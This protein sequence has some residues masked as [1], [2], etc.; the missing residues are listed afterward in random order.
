MDIRSLCRRH[1]K[2]YLTIGNVKFAQVLND[3]LFCPP[4]SS[5]CLTWCVRFFCLIPI[6]DDFAVVD[7]CLGVVGNYQFA[8]YVEYA[9]LDAEGFVIFND[10]V[11]IIVCDVFQKDTDTAHGN[12]ALSI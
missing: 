3:Y 1:E 11:A 2:K 5:V 12:D 6:Q 4:I 10:Q 8:S 9:V 7:F